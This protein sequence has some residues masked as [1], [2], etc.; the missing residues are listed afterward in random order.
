MKQP[1]VTAIYYKVG[2]IKMTIAKAAHIKAAYIFVNKNHLLHIAGTHTKELQALGFTAKDFVKHVA[3]SFTRI[4]KDKK[5]NA[6]FLVVY[7]PEIT[8]SAVIQLNYV[9]NFE[10]WE[11]KTAAPYR[12]AFFKNKLLVWRKGAHPLK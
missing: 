6:L 7:H 5:T 12:T 3:Q 4:Y 2:R 10:F 11:I 1:K 8:H 9:E